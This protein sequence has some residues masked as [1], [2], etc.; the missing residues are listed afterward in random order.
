V[1]FIPSNI[2]GKSFAAF[3]FKK[4]KVPESQEL[5]TKIMIPTALEI[6]LKPVI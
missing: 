4:K 5:F 3:R 2:F 6:M 1:T